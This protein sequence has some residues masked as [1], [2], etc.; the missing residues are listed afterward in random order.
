MSRDVP[1]LVW[2]LAVAAGLFSLAVATRRLNLW[3]A[4]FGVVFIALV[5]LA[6]TLEVST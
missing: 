3:F 5:L 6:W 4:V 1:T 2:L